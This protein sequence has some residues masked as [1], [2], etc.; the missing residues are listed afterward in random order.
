METNMPLEPRL[1]TDIPPT[2]LE[3][4]QRL[5]RDL[6]TARW[7]SHKAMEDYQTKLDDAN[8]TIAD[9]RVQLDQ[10]RHTLSLL[11]NKEITERND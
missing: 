7:T 3:T 5:E 1:R 10:M 9:L 6:F 4:I 2:D 11:Q 8:Q